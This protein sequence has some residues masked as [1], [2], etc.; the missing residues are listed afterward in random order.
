[1]TSRLFRQVLGTFLL[2]S[3][4]FMGW[5]QVAGADSRPN[6]LFI[7]TDQHHAKMLSAAGNPYLKT[8]AL[9][10]IAE[11]GIRFTNAYAANPVCMPSRL[12][13]ATGMMPGRFGVFNNGMEATMPEEVT[14][15][16]LG[17]LMKRAGYATF[18]GGKTHLPTELEPRNGGYDV[19]VKD[20]R[21]E[22]PGA[23]LEFIT[24][25]RDEPFF[26]VAS[27]INPH[28]ICFAYNS[29]VADPD[30]KGL[31]LVDR[32]YKEAQA[33]PED[34]LPPLPYNSGIP[35]N[36][37]SGIQENLKVDA[38]TP[39]K[40]IREDYTDRDWR[41]YRWIYC[42]L[43]ERVDAQI[44]ELMDGL[45]KQGLDEDTLI[46]FT[47]DHGDM[48]GSHRLASKNLFYEESAGVPYLMQ[49]K[50]VIPRG[51]VDDKS[52]VSSGLNTL[53]TLAE[54]AGVGVPD[55][56][57]GRSLRSVA[58]TGTDK[59]RRPYVVS[60]NDIGRMLRTERYKYCVY[61]TGEPRESLVDMK[62]DPGEMR[63]LAV[64]PEYKDIVVRHR[65]F[66]QQWIE[67]SGDEESKSF[68]IVPNG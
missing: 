11:S 60:E 34:Q 35:E 24:T 28:D 37:P 53:P 51:V 36:E 2:S 63:N 43:T 48:D 38:I 44:G 42:R 59:P 3:L 68:A 20:Q 61:T 45:E 6:I 57:L 49:Y 52:L 65:R 8:R 23:C 25:D 66:L 58:E 46:V 40:L 4:N 67:E 12:S 1:M 30:R 17:K 7:I 21:D 19:I 5:A 14:A 54:Y 31:A 22:L 16:S 55:F 62:K 29:R 9:D 13:M 47:A 56:L 15:N 41:N 27:F 26:A 18:Y 50:G 10:S 39:A 33:I 64:L 32:L